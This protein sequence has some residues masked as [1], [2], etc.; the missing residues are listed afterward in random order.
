MELEQ[1][2]KL[3]ANDKTVHEIS[4]KAAK[5]S[6]FICDLLADFKDTQIQV[7]EAN[8]PT[9]KEIVEYL[10]HY[11]DD[12]PKDIDCPLEEDAVMEDLVEKWD[13]DFVK[14]SDDLQR[15]Q[16]LIVAADFMGIESLHDLM[17]S[18]MAC[19]CI[20][21]GSSEEIIK[22]FNIEE[23][24]TQEEMDLMEKEEL[25]KKRKERADEFEL[26]NQKKQEETKKNEDGET[27]NK[28]DN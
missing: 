17:I 13:L 26:M 9:L 10:E 19:I 16:D 11:K 4:S 3:E 25:A 5:R 28:V 8:G 24:I 21:L 12:E 27:E 20:K 18:E 14:R 7:A 2:I 23:D 22:H 6:K 1:I 15:L